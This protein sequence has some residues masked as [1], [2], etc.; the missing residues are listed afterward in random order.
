MAFSIAATVGVLVRLDREQTREIDR[1]RCELQLNRRLQ[2]QL[3]V[4]ECGLLHAG[5][6]SGSLV[7][8]QNLPAPCDQVLERVVVDHPCSSHLDTPQLW[9]D[10]CQI[11]SA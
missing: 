8:L 2:H 9:I 6:G 3:R 10:L 7:L 5:C 11:Y 1:D 4:L